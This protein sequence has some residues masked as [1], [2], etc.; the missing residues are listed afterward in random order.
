MLPFRADEDSQLGLRLSQ[1]WAH[2][3]VHVV[4]LTFE[5]SSAGAVLQSHGFH[6]GC[7]LRQ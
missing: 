6:A 7:L 1:G 4:P 5:C 2:D 3:I